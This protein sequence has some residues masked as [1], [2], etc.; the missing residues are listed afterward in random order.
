MKMQMLLL[1]VLGCG[2]SA[3]AQKPGDCV[4]ENPTHCDCCGPHGCFVWEFPD[5][6]CEPGDE[7]GNCSSTH[8]PPYT[9]QECTE[10]CRGMPTCGG[11]NLPNGH[12]KKLGC[13]DTMIPWPAKGD[14]P[15]LRLFTMNLYPQRREYW[16]KFQKTNC[17]NHYNELG[18]CT[19]E[20][21]ITNPTPAE[22]MEFEADYLAHCK[23]VCT[24]N[25]FCEGF[26]F[27]KG[28][29][30]AMGC[31]HDQESTQEPT[32][33]LRRGHPQ[34]RPQNATVL[35]SLP[36]HDCAGGFEL[37]NCSSF[38]PPPYTESMCKKAC[39]AN[40]MCGGWN[41]PN[42]HLKTADC[43]QEVRTGSHQD[44]YYFTTKA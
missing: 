5:T 13:S 37:G 22:K 41:L 4:C 21:N 19:M 30:K 12:L 23:Q 8:A 3:G 11:F 16:W 10:T 28:H 40:P 33:Y 25:P 9:V 42:G 18:N 29:L 14:R 39:E 35:V 24:D 27:P 32:L 34:P 44:L 31:R 2:T 6:D 38:L 26:N 7:L 15:A 20:I 43:A 17:N 1:A 36:G